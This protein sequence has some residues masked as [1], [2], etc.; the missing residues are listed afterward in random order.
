MPVL[1]VEQADLLSGDDDAGPR[2]K[3][4][5]QR[6]S[7][8]QPVLQ[9]EPVGAEF[10]RDP[11][12]RVVGLQQQPVHR[13][14]EGLPRASGPVLPLDDAVADDAQFVVVE[15]DAGLHADGQCPRPVA[16]VEQVLVAV[17]F[18]QRRGQLGRHVA[19]AISAGN[20]TDSGAALGGLGW[21]LTSVTVSKCSLT[22]PRGGAAPPAGV[23]TGLLAR[24]RL[25]QLSRRTARQD[26]AALVDERDVHGARR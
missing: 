2:P 11:A 20:A 10:K 8:R 26:P 1:G 14:A 22:Y 23:M 5:R 17:A 19:G 6:G 16:L 24:R 12:E 7:R 25:Q 9:P 13:L 18:R 21:A 3:H 4:P 15:L